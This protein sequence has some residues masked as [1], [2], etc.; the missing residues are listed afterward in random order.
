MSNFK[1]SKIF[2]NISNKKTIKYQL[3]SKLLIDNSIGT[4]T[5]YFNFPNTD[6]QINKQITINSP[7]R[8]KKENK[9]IKFFSPLTQRTS[10]LDI[11]KNLLQLSENKA[12]SF[13]TQKKIN[14]VY[15]ESNI[16]NQSKK[17]LNN[18]SHEILLNNN[19]IKSRIPI[20]NNILKLKPKIKEI[21][22]S[23]L[24][25]VTALNKQT[26]S[27]FNNKYNLFYKTRNF[28]KKKQIKNCFNLIQK[29]TNISEI[30]NILNGPKEII[31]YQIQTEPNQE[32]NYWKLN[33][34]YNMKFNRIKNRI[35]SSKRITINALG[36]PFIK[37][38]KSILFQ[39]KPTEL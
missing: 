30:N 39:R 11:K 7:K 18:N 8:I 35:N 38:S 16:N 24:D 20:R 17:M 19:Y 15:S 10:F 28:K 6:R 3:K 4:N 29:G 14:S 1:V 13:N 21:I 22:N 9:E 31:T 33:E 5:K 36:F 27:N 23:D 34:I 12:D 26:N 32:N 2:L 25:L 37:Q